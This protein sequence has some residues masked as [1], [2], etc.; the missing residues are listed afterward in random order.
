[1][2]DD[3]Q[4]DNPF[5]HDG[6]YCLKRAAR[7]LKERMDRDS[8]YDSAIYYAFGVEK[9]CKAIVHD[10]NPVFLLE[11]HGF[12]NAI[13]AVHEDRLTTRALKKVDKDVNRSLIA[14]NPTLIRA[15]KF[16]QAVED[17]MGRFMELANIRGALAHRTVWELN[18]ERSSEFLL[19]TFVPTVELFAEAIV[20][21]ALECFDSAEQ[22][23]VLK[24][25]SDNLFAQENYGEF[26]KD[27]L[28][29]HLAIWEAR[30]D[31]PAA[32]QKAATATETHTQNYHHRPAY[33][34]D[35]ICPCCKQPAIL[36]FRFADVYIPNEIVTAALMRLGC[37]AITAI[38]I[39]PDTGQ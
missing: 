12:D 24:K 28:A 36:I 9:L 11:S 29:R 38:S 21:E 2:D 37:S 35:G 17:N 32:V 22:Y 20:F 25:I 1:M 4:I 31:D 23:H 6:I 27:I 7:A 15:A 18:G 34:N 26:I 8:L 33:A 3:G 13:C 16:S 14:F 5:V 39:F 10:V 19:R 30:K